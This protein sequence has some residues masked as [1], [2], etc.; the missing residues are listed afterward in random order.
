MSKTQIGI[1]IIWGV[2]LTGGHFYSRNV[3]RF[4]PEFMMPSFAGGIFAE[5]GFESNSYMIRVKTSDS[6]YSLN[7]HEFLSVYPAMNPINIY[8]NVITTIPKMSKETR[9]TYIRELLKNK[10]NKPIEQF[11][12]IGISELYTL[13][14][15]Q[16]KLKSRKEKLIFQDEAF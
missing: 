16:A 3:T 7:Y 8:R 6:I 11:Q 14:N 13:K 10:T 2:L 12:I 4:F 5:G 9:K 15:C 1:C